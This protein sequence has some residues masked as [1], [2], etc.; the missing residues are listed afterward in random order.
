ME[1][2]ILFSEEAL[3]I[4]LG[5]GA[6]RGDDP[7]E[8]RRIRRAAELLPGR[9]LPA[10]D[11]GECAHAVAA[12]Y[13]FPHYKDPGGLNR[14]SRGARDQDQT[15]D[16]GDRAD[17]ASDALAGGGEAF[18]GDRRRDHGHRA[19]VHDADDEQDRHQAGAAEAALD[20]ELQAVSQAV[21]ASAGS[22][23]PARRASRGSRP[24]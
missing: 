11:A 19:K 15:R 18:D 4:E 7:E 1:R 17:R 12:H 9:T 23:R 10:L 2:A 8:T 21:P 20:A 13:A 5:E 6:E 3:E 24:R 14:L 22:A 16:D